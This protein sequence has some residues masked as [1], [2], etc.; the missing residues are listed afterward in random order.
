MD[1]RTFLGQIEMYDRLIDSK[2]AELCRL[3]SMATSCTVPTDR[4]GSGSSGVSDKVGSV[5]ARIC[6]LEQSLAETIEAYLEARNRC[7]EIIESVRPPIYYTVLHKYHIQYM[8]L[9]EIAEDI[10]YEYHYVCDLHRKAIAKVQE[11]LDGLGDAAEK[12]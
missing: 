11:V 2:K 6:D 3:R 9:V 4:E 12:L 7:I 8:S 10:G 1:A 5:V